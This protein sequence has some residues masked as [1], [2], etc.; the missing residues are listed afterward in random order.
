MHYRK[1]RSL[2]GLVVLIGLLVTACLVALD[3]WAADTPA[4]T[5]ISNFAIGNYKDVNG[6]SLPQVRSNT[7]TTMVAAVPARISLVSD[8]ALIIGNGEDISILTATVEDSLGNP[9]P[10][11]VPVVFE[12][13]EGTF[14]NG[15]QRIELRTEGGVVSTTLR[16]D[17]VSTEIVH[18]LARATAG[19]ELSGKVSTEVEIVFFPGA[20]MG[21]VVEHG[22][23]RIIEEAIVVVEDEGGKFVGA[24]TTGLDGVYLIPVA[25]SGNYT[26]RITITDPF[27]R[28]VTSVSTVRIE[29]PGQGGLP[30]VRNWCAISGATLDA[31]DRRP[32]EEV[33][34]EI[35]LYRRTEGGGAAKSLGSRYVQATGTDSLC[36]TTATDSTGRYI[37][38][39][40]EPGNYRVGAR[41]RGEQFYGDGGIVVT[42]IDQGMFV[43]NADISL[44]RIGHL[45]LT[46]SAP[47]TA[48]AGS[49]FGYTLIYANNGA[50][51]ALNA[52]L[53]DTLPTKVSFVS[54]SGE[55][56]AS[57]GIV[58]WELGD[59]QAGEQG[60]V[61]VEVEV[62]LTVQDGISVV[63]TAHLCAE[64]VEP[65]QASARTVVRAFPQ[66]VLTKVADRDTVRIGGTFDYTLT[67][68]NIGGAPTLNVTVSDTLSP[69]LALVSVSEEAPHRGAI[70]LW[71]V[72]DLAPGEADT[73]WV[74]TTVPIHIAHGQRIRNR[75]WVT[76]DNAETMLDSAV[77]IARGEP[78][79]RISKAADLTEGRLGETVTYTVVVGNRGTRDAQEVTV[80]DHLASALLYVEGSSPPEAAYVP[81]TRILAWSPGTVARGT[82]DTLTF[83]IRIDGDLTPGTHIVENTAQLLVGGVPIVSS[84]TVTLYV[85]VPYLKIEKSANKT[86]GEPGD[87]VRYQVTVTNASV[88]DSVYD[89]QIEDHLPHSF[90]YVAGTTLVDR[91][92]TS[93]PS[94]V[95]PVRWAIGDLGPSESRKVH[96]LTVIGAGAE[97]G[98]G[99]NKAMASGRAAGPFAGALLQTGP[100]SKQV[101]IRPSL[102]APGE[103][104]LGKVW[105]DANGNRIHD[106]GEY[107]VS[108]VVL[109]LEDGTRVTTDEYGN[110]SIPEVKSGDHVVRLLEKSLPPGLR[111]M[112]PRNAFAGDP[113]SQFVSLPKYA[114][115][116]ANFMLVETA[117]PFGKRAAR[118]VPSE[119]LTLLKRVIPERV[120]VPVETKV[121]R[122]GAAYFQTG[123]EQI[124]P[125]MRS[126]PE[127]VCAHLVDALHIR[128]EGHTDSRPMRTARFPSNQELSEARAQAVMAFLS[129]A[130]GIERERMTVVGYGATRPIASNATPEGR[131][132]N[133]RVEVIAAHE[134]LESKVKV[135]YELT[136]DYTG[137]EPARGVTLVDSLPV[138]VRL[139]EGGSVEGADARVQVDSLGRMVWDLGEFSSEQEVRVGFDVEVEV[140]GLDSLVNQAYLWSR[141]EGRLTSDRDEAVLYIDREDSS[142]GATG[143]RRSNLH[144]RIVPNRTVVPLDS[145]MT[146]E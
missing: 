137:E 124:R 102:F 99:V 60:T 70:L 136:V 68:R 130:C 86:V 17:V 126:K 41:Y 88:S 20:V 53:V 64:A 36:A 91:R 96:Y 140:A 45:V 103:V 105:V 73:L 54:A 110:Y 30:P 63:N 109:I 65:A 129:E 142:E 29:V 6:N 35:S 79:L 132:R 92:H 12:T 47:D 24:D 118:V 32:I 122:I 115:A 8:P 82:A 76:S 66:L 13:T 5:V 84:S 111:P 144:E 75:A 18:A 113:L 19:T 141:S 62:R 7:V 133:R 50:V 78:D 98:D 146:G 120:S 117:V 94:G 69:D 71:S 55:A 11:G 14:E 59:L 121:V 26:V 4:G 22:T 101:L 40:V 134:K 2:H 49:C 74:T 1:Q 37:F 112:I 28:K 108:G 80:E 131:A 9:V 25:R 106:H 15:A 114:M 116:K 61:S 125:E 139:L 34:T 27:G 93:D 104:I 127:E 135:R 87:I 21:T 58:R 72:G 39:M 67:V 119:V 48:T 43:V 143:G 33:G 128:V 89:I 145:T 90:D 42:D 85:L 38:N 97:N 51:D 138:Q 56:S 44:N 57:E 77:V 16:A 100:A 83:Q 10:D 123:S 3:G 46:K 23:G 31:L 81:E 107:T 52:A 95:Q